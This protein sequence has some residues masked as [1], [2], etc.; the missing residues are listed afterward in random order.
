[1]RTITRNVTAA[2]MGDPKPNY[3]A[4]DDDEAPA[5]ADPV[6]T[7]RYRPATGS[8]L[9]AGAAEASE[10]I[11]QQPAG[12]GEPMSQI[13]ASTDE[14][15][16]DIAVAPKTPD[17]AASE[18][19]TLAGEGVER[20]AEDPAGLSPKIG[21][22]LEPVGALRPVAPI[23]V[24]GLALGAILTGPPICEDVDP[25]SLLVDASYQRDLSDKSIKLI[26][27][28]ASEWDW[29]R[30]KPP[31][32]AFA[33][34][35]LQII[36]GQHTAIGA[37]SRPDITS[38]PVMVVEAPELQA[39]ALAFIGHNRDR[40]QVTPMQ[41][42]HAAVA[43]GDDV[44]VTIEQV[45]E[46]AGV[47]LVRSAFGGYRYKVGETVA[48][49]AIRGLIDRKGAQFARRTLQALVQADLAPIA[50]NEIKAAEFL[51]TD[52]DHADQLEPLGDGEGTG[53]GDLAAAIKS[54]GGGADREAK[55]FAA[56]QRVPMWRAMAVIWF[57]KT[58]KR[59]KP[60]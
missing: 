14:G 23:A 33:D 21:E 45:C 36:D 5:A 30:F 24:D 41:M 11:G 48:I 22:N 42:H 20:G 17:L 54:L 50:A 27:K 38:I 18:P 15:N 35:G 29:R 8:Y 43:A 44:A 51:F 13:P 4:P 52:P 55:L 60:S 47:T 34:G 32:C 46:R 6:E 39:R 25:R 53:G 12:H 57:R 37:A 7:L 19:E 10:E 1:M 56:A 16:C 59:R 40:L 9:T 28:I 49:S 31:V 58:R 2:L 26:Q 3:V